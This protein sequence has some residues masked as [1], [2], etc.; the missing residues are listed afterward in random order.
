LFKLVAHLKNGKGFLQ[1]GQFTILS[2]QIE[3][4]KIFVKKK[5]VPIF[6]FRKKEAKNRR[7]TNR[8]NS[9]TISQIDLPALKRIFN[10]RGNF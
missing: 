3:T 9:T 7:L 8:K 1:T 2:L 6:F 4:I 10:S 5:K